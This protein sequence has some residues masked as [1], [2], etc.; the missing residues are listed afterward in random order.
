[1]K[2]RGG[3]CHMLN[4]EGRKEKKAKLR[5]RNGIPRPEYFSGRAGFGLGSKKFMLFRAEKSCP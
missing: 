4:L 2:V 5:T 3:F 1:M